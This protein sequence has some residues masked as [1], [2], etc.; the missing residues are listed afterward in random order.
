M[1]V[2]VSLSCCIAEIEAFINIPYTCIVRHVSKHSEHNAGECSIFKCFCFS[3][4]ATNIAHISIF[5]VAET[6]VYTYT[7]FKCIVLRALLDTFHNGSAWGV[8]I[9]ASFGYTATENFG[10]QND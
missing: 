2:F 8:C 10:V 9:N 6:G 3:H 4:T 1:T 7:L 5:C